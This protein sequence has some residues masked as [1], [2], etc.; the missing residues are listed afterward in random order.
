MKLMTPTKLYLPNDNQAV[1]KFLTFQ[2]RSV[3]YQIRKVKANIKWQQHHPETFYERLKELQT[4]KTRTLLFY[5]D[6]GQP[7]TYSGLWRD[8]QM[9]F[10][11]SVQNVC[12]NQYPA[13]YSLNIAWQNPPPPM[14]YYQQMAVEAL[15]QARHG[16]VELPVASGKTLV[17]LNLSKALPVKTLIVVHSV[18]LATQLYKAYVSAFGQRWVGLY[19]NKKTEYN[20]LF[21][22]ATAQSLTRLQPHQKAYEELS[23]STVLCW[24]ECH[25]TPATT[26]ETV[27]LGLAKDIPYRFFVS[28]T[29]LRTDGSDLVLRGIIGPVVYKKTY[30]ELVQDGYISPI[31]F[32]HFNVPSVSGKA[33]VND[34]NKETQIHLYYNSVVH[35][36]AADVAN[37]TI[38]FTNRQV[39]ILIEEFKQFL[40][41][42]NYLNV[43]YEF[44]HGNVTPKVKEVLPPEYW[45]CDIPKIVEKFNNGEI[46]L[47][48][49]TTVI[50]VGIDLKPVE[51]LI[52]LQGD[53]SEIK[54]R[55]ALGRGARL[56]GNKTD[57]WVVDFN[58]IGSPILERHFKL[59]KDIYERLIQ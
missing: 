21:T 27:C 37:K 45:H 12:S 38:K 31:V 44:V 59:R 10:Q 54:V 19:G 8:L 56:V 47:L 46:R 52:Y 29:P 7:W 4:Q 35:Q 36:I 3:M 58:V 50:G 20:K 23:K 9:R 2:D 5:D 14:R 32:K 18:A 48:I 40:L 17:L 26:F 34:A 39:L 15:L 53:A 22:V 41:L 16:C 57:C 24:D 42:R 13:P 6:E 28:A 51:C 43:P 33:H 11:W 49:G 1:K 30:R 55:Q 25:V